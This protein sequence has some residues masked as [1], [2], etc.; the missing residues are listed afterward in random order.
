MPA[1]HQRDASFPRDTEPPYRNSETMARQ[2][3]ICLK[4][5]EEPS[6]AADP[7]TGPPGAITEDGTVANDLPPID[8]PAP[9]DNGGFTNELP[10]VFPPPEPDPLPMPL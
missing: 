8:A 9:V 5:R 7:V 3:Y 6:A 2:V 10:V 4:T 1:R